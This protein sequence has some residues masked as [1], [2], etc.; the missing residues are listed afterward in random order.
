MYVPIATYM[1][2]FLKYR[3]IIGSVYDTAAAELLTIAHKRLT[4]AQFVSK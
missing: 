2:R 3:I 1:M 4:D